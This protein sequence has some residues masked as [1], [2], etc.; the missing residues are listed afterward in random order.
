MAE[1]AG[2]L[3]VGA[4]CITYGQDATLFVRQ[5]DLAGFVAASTD[6]GTTWGNVT[7]VGAFP[8]ESPGMGEGGGGAL[9]TPAAAAVD[10]AL[11][12]AYALRFAGRFSAPTFTSCG[13]G[14]PCP[15]PDSSLSWT[16]VW[17]A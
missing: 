11:C 2:T 14:L 15:D 6:N 13:A 16:C 8:G 12:A 4:T 5:H 1:L 10:A 17:S 9:C 7:A 3:F